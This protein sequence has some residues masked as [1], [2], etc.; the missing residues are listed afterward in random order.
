MSDALQAI[1]V[2]SSI[3]LSRCLVEIASVDCVSKCRVITNVAF[4]YVAMKPNG[5]RNDV[6][7]EYT[8]GAPEPLLLQISIHI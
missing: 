2:L 7:C 1:V 6:R 8:G 4:C 5:H 3:E